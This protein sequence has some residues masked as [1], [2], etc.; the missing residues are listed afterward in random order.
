LDRVDH[1]VHHDLIDLGPVALDARE[2]M[3]EL[4][5]DPDAALRLELDQ[6]ER[7]GDAVVEI[8]GAGV[9]PTAMGKRA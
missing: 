3:V 5:H 9:D 1:Q 4:A 7:R 8:E 6:T 2:V